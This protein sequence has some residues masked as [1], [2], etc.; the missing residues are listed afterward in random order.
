MLYFRTLIYFPSISRRNFRTRT[1][2]FFSARTRTRTRTQIPD[3]SVS[4]LFPYQVFQISS[5]LRTN[6]VRTLGTEDGKY[7]DSVS[8]L[9]GMV[10]T[11]I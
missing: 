2:I 4:V 5:V 10:Y 11:Y 7:T 8:L 6:S 3:D 1:P 9:R